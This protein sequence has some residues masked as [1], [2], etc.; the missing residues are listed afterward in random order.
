MGMSLDSK[1]DIGISSK[2]EKFSNEVD[3]DLDDDEFL[4]CNTRGNIALRMIMYE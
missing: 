2:A 1:E 4:N 3:M